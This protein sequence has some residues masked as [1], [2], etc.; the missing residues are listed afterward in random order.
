MA[1]SSGE[2]IKR[3]STKG[4][5]FNPHYLDLYIGTSYFPDIL[6]SNERFAKNVFDVFINI[7]EFLISNNN[8]N[9]YDAEKLGGL[10]RVII[11]QSPK[12]PDM[13]KYVEQ[14]LEVQKKLKNHFIV[15]KTKSSEKMVREIKNDFKSYLSLMRSRNIDN[16][17]L[18]NLIEKYI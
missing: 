5:L 15:N 9:E 4:E 3:F 2:A 12:I 10:C 17:S 11:G 18:K 14:I 7:I 13:N 8:F 16:E 1:F 6:G